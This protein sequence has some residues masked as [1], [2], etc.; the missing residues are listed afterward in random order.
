V[1][2]VGE[3]TLASENTKFRCI[4][5]SRGKRK[6]DG[7]PYLNPVAV[8]PRLVEPWWQFE[9]DDEFDI[10]EVIIYAGKSFPNADSNLIN[11]RITICGTSS[12]NPSSSPTDRPTT[13]ES[14][15]PSESPTIPPTSATDS[16]AGTG[17][18]QV[19]EDIKYGNKVVPTGIISIPVDRYGKI[20]R[21]TLEGENQRALGLS[22]V[23]IFGR[24]EENNLQKIETSVF[25]LLPT[26]NS[27]IRYI[28]FVQ[29]DDEFPSDGD[30]P[31][32][33]GA[34]KSE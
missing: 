6:Y 24:V 22:E 9:F 14:D 5:N 17:Y 7:N 32:H 4:A 27:E 30:S 34:V 19:G 25:D 21:I 8:T 26:L 13:V 1:K 10:S 16:C 33:S 11:F 18:S 12:N 31:I 23:K 20:V 28:A 3:K 2:R 15:T 29:D